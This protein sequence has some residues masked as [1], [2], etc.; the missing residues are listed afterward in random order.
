MADNN[1][2]PRP[3]K[4]QAIFP[5][6]IRGE[7][8]PYILFYATQYVDL[9]RLSADTE[10]SSAVQKIS[11]QDVGPD[12]KPISSEVQ[13][14]QPL[15]TI[16]LPIPAD[17]QNSIAPGWAVQDSIATTAIADLAS[18]FRSGG[19]SIG[20]LG[21]GIVKLGAS[22]IS[23]TGGTTLGRLGGL[24]VNPKKQALFG[25]IETRE[26]V[27]SYILTPQSLPEAE[28]IQKIVTLFNKYSLPSLSNSLGTDAFLNFPP[29]WHITFNGVK[30]FPDIKKCV[31]TG[32]VTN[33]SPGAMQLLKSGHAVQTSIAVSF[34]EIDIRTQ[35]SYGIGK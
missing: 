33:W 18:K 30:G 22:G 20:D 24:A 13:I 26:F 15:C 27:F 6:A 28:E 7:D 5:K 32:V 19:I 10:K 4:E 21:Q 11:T 34:K 14:P 12:N 1:F 2:G 16:Y 8:F 9:F 35:E 23:A 31:C 25:G 29:E 3:S 17:I